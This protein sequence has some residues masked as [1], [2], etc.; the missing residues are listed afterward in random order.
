MWLLTALSLRRAYPSLLLQASADRSLADAGAEKAQL[1]DPS[2]LR[3]LEP[4]LTSGDPSECRAA[5][6]LVAAAPAELAVGPLARAVEAAPDDS[7]AIVIDALHRTVEPL[8][9]GSLRDRP[10]RPQPCARFRR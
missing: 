3:A 6:D 2:T 5:V 7:R 1:L 9:A 4:H 8:P 10:R